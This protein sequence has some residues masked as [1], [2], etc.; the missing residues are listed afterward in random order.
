MKTGTG[1]TDR[2]RKT[3]WKRDW[4]HTRMNKDRVYNK[5]FYPNE[6]AMRLNKKSLA[7]CLVC[8]SFM[9]SS[10]FSG[11]SFPRPLYRLF[12]IS[13]IF[14][15]QK[16]GMLFQAGQ[17]TFFGWCPPYRPHKNSGGLQNGNNAQTV[18]KRFAFQ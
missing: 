1:E 12:A 7:G 6:P 3:R 4:R 14:S 16:T 18:F 5:W 9:L 13:V 15:P 2:F 10:C 17:Q 11:L 8:T